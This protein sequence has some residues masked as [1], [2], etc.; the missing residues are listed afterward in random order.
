MLLK[1]P[2]FTLIA[3]LTLSLGIGTTTAI[4]SPANIAQSRP[5]LVAQP[6]EDGRLASV[7]RRQPNHTSIIYSVTFSPDGRL[8]AS[9]SWDGTVKL[10]AASSGRELRTLAGHSRGIYRA[11]FSPD[12]RW[13][14]TASRD[15][16][17][18]VWDVT[19]GRERRTLMGHIAAVKSVA[20]SPDG[21]ML[22]SGGNDGTV[23][24]WEAATG[25]EV[26]RCKHETTAGTAPPV[27][28]VAWSPNGSWIAAG[29]GD[30][31][32]SLW[33]AATGREVRLLKG[34]MFSLSFSPDTR[35]L[36]SINNGRS[37]EGQVKLFDVTTG[38]LIRT[39]GDAPAK[40]I[41]NAVLSVEWSPD[42]RLLASGEGRINQQLRQYQGRIRL[43]DAATG[44][45]LRAVDA[46]VEGT[47]SIAFNP[48]GR[49]LVSGSEDATIK[50]WRLPKLTLARKLSVGVSEAS[51][52]K[53]FSL[54]SMSNAQQQL[55]QSVAGERLKDWLLEFNGGNVFVMRGFNQE[56]Y[57]KA[58]LARISADQLALADARSYKK[59][60]ALSVSSI[61]RASENEIIVL[62][63]TARTGAR[64]RIRLQTEEA[65]PHGI[66]VIEIQ[67]VPAK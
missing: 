39:L 66:T 3:V 63:Q 46:H 29:N 15:W 61:E 26:R 50:L 4:F 14:A 60:G 47:G 25:R 7:Y 42:G 53:S 19:T 23:R 38:E 6:A 56:S 10:W 43:W 36:A 13:L 57:A 62:A 12:G 33:E 31:S 9:A 21:R 30:R 1:Q 32:V 16:T 64:I 55:N 24:W 22:A 5:L 27:F 28:S 51:G 44:R 52:T 58:T 67:P 41:V 48:D 45:E 59:F 65:A 54:D 2:G 18:K 8:I 11:V 37:G 35:R 20:W 34:S 49:S 40:E 17:V